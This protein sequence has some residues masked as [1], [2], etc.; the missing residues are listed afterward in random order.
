MKNLKRKLAVLCLSAVL[1]VP[2]ISSALQKNLGQSGTGIST[3]SLPSRPPYGSVLPDD[4]EI[5]D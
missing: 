5:H 4:I 3:C 1:T 2:L